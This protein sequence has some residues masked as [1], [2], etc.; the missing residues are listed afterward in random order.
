[1]QVYQNELKWSKWTEVNTNGPKG[2]KCT[3]WTK[4]D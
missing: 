3:E 4:Q 2:T 1:M